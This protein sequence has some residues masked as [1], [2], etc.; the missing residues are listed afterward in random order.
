MDNPANR[1]DDLVKKERETEEPG[2]P[3]PQDRGYSF[4]NPMNEDPG[5]PGEE[6]L[7]SELE[8]EFEILDEGNADQLINDQGMMDIKS[9]RDRLQQRAHERLQ[10]LRGLNKAEMNAD[11]F[12]EKL[13]VPAYLRKDVKL[14][15]VPHSSEP[16]VSKY[17]LNDDNQ[18]LGNNKF[19][20]DN[21]DWS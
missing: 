3:T 15:N 12:K 1:P 20:H 9:T 21:V 7:F 19:L 13:D 5:D 8:E 16:H 4:A 10:K 18:I 6:G 14:Q 11:E 2:K 17:N